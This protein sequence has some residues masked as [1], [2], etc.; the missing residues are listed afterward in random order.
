VGVVHFE[1]AGHTVVGVGKVHALR[2]QGTHALITA[3][4]RVS[5]VV[6]VL[7]G[8]EGAYIECV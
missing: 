8:E 4:E 6:S 3:Q 2:A 1:G 5:G 7:S